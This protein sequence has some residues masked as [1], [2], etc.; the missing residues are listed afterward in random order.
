MAYLEGSDT[1][2]AKALLAKIPEVGRWDDLFVFKTKTMK[3]AAYDMLGDA[4]RAKNG[5][6]AKWTPRKGEVAR[7]I[8][9]HFGARVADIVMGCTDGVPDA[10]GKKPPWRQ[11]KERYLAH[12]EMA[13]KDVLLVSGSDKLHNA[14]AILADLHT[15]GVS[16]FDRFTAS[17]ED[18]I[19]YYTSLSEIFSR[20]AVPV[21][22]ALSDTVSQMRAYQ[23]GTINV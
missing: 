19:W 11:R 12:L 22:V 1:D 21:A 15:V 9:E 16:V 17:K 10:T 6:A 5:L 23:Q 14:R 2:A 13:A 3:T 18:T 20:R 8:R 4:L 7:E